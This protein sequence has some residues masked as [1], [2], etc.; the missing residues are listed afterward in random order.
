MASLADQPVQKLNMII[1][2]NSKSGK[3]GGLASLVEAGFNLRILDFDNGLDPLVLFLKKKNPEL[4][5]KVEAVTLTDK[6][7]SIAGKLQP[8]GVPTAFTRACNLLTD[9]KPYPDIPD[10]Q[11]M[12]KIETWTPNEIL[13]IDSVTFMGRAALRRTLFN[14]KRL[15]QTPYQS[16]WGDAQSELEMVFATLFDDSIKCSILYLTHIDIREDD[17]V[18]MVQGNPM[19]L[20]KALGPV[21][22]RYTNASVIVKNIN[23]KRSIKTNPE[24]FIDTAFPAPG[25][26][27]SYPLE[28]GYADLFR[29]AGITPKKE[30]T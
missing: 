30:T 9:W 2:G 25:V 24:L 21:F 29:A 28:T 13:V 10:A 20:G 26:A 18:G 16:D 27:E 15:G 11:K 7:G 17:K 8:M 1:M 14:N 23:G 5:K 19:V 22:P 4:L 6:H 12:G 3:T